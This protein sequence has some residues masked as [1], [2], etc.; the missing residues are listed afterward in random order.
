MQA[1]GP[2][3]KKEEELPC[4]E[5]RKIRLEK[6]RTERQSTCKNKISGPRRAGGLGPGQ[7]KWNKGFSK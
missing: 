1:R 7:P 4:W 3:K 2:P 5:S 6:W